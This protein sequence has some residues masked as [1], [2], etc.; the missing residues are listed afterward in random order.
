MLRGFLPRVPASTEP[1]P[2]KKLTP[3]LVPA[4]P[5][6]QKPAAS[7]AIPLPPLFRHFVAK[8]LQLLLCSQLLQ[9]PW[10]FLV[11][12]SNLL[13]WLPSRGFP[14]GFSSPAPQHFLCSPGSHGC[15]LLRGFCLC[16]GREVFSVGALY[17]T[18]DQ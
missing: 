4:S 1:S 18:K 5:S 6:A 8:Y 14:A 17:Q 12:A 13:S 16:L 3:S 9:H 15:A 2:L 11:M 7:S 10:R